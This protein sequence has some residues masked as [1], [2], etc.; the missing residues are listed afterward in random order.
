MFSLLHE[1]MQISFDY[2]IITNKPK[3]IDSDNKNWIIPIKVTAKA[4]KNIDI[5]AKYFLNILKALSLTETEI[6]DYKSLNKE[7]FTVSVYYNNSE[8]TFY[9]RK[10]KSIDILYTF[11]MQWEYYTKSFI[12]SNGIDNSLESGVSKLHIFSNITNDNK[13]HK[14]ISLFF[15]SANQVAGSFTWEENLSLAKIEQITEDSETPYFVKQTGIRST[16]KYG[17]FVLF[18]NEGHGLVAAIIDIGDIDCENAKIEC[19]K[20]ELNGFIDWYF[21]DDNEL[22]LMYKNLQKFG[23]GGFVNKYYMSS[24]N[25]YKV[26][27]ID[28][29]SGNSGEYECYSNIARVRAIRKY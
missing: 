5:C 16:I 8:N 29:G 10:Q 4:N 17:G 9:L 27:E 20:F 28:F 2:S 11:A 19:D 13:K 25:D 22:K 23:L 1:T 6:A 7:F 15:L 12:V 18:E 26:W 21:P 14:N 3:S 24:Y